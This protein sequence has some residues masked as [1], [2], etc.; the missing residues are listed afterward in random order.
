MQVSEKL[1]HD[2]IRIFSD[3]PQVPLVKP[4]LEDF[5]VGGYATVLSLVDPWRHMSHQIDLQIQIT[6]NATQKP[7]K[8]LLTP[9]GEV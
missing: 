8:D 4:R 2:Y 3:K 5:M 1:T 9:R 6:S 7:V